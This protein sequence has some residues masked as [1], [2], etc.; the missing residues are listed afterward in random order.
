M[1]QKNVSV[2]ECVLYLFISVLSFGVFYLG[3]GGWGGV[4]QTLYLF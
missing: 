3:G 1:N 2:I 4:D